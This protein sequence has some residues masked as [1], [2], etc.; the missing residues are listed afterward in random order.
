M[1]DRHRFETHNRRSIERLNQRGGRMLSLVDL[2]KAGTVSLELAEELT[3]VVASGG[4]FLTAAGPGGVGKTTLMGALLGLIPPCTEIIAVEGRQALDS[5]ER[6]Q[7]D[8]RQC[9]L[10]HEIGSGPYYSY[11]WGPLV[12]RYFGLRGPGRILASNL[13]ATTYA[14]ARQALTEEPLGVSPEDF[15]R[16]DLLAFMVREY[17]KRRVT[18]VWKRRRSGDGHEQTWRWQPHSDS[19]NRTITQADP[20]PRADPPKTGPTPASAEQGSSTGPSLQLIR[21]FLEE[22]LDEDCILL[23]DLREKALRRLF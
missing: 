17:G 11:L 10:V 5:L 13:H 23:A 4:S 22:A 16:I 21:S 1:R 3:F 9:L 14:E 18:S 8:H 7:P 2:I 15:R 19:F 20:P 12:G 6:S